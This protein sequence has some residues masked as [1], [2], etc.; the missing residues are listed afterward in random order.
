MSVEDMRKRP[1]VGEN[2]NAQKVAV[3]WN[4]QTSF[5][6]MGEGLCQSSPSARKLYDYT[7]RTLGVSL[8]SLHLKDLE[9][10]DTQGVQ[11]A[12]AP[13]NMASWNELRALYPGL[14]IQ[15]LGGH[16][17]GE[18]FASVPAGAVT[19]DNFLAFL[20]TR[21]ELMKSVNEQNPGA[22][23]ALTTRR[24][25]T[26][27][28]RDEKLQAFPEISRELQEKFGV[29]VATYSSSSRQTIGGRLEAVQEA[30][31]YAKRLR[32]YVVAQIISLN[33]APHTSLYAPIVDDLRSAIRSIR[34]GIVDPVIP[35]LT[36]SKPNPEIMTT[37]QAIE[38]EIVAQATQPVYGDKQQAFLL[39][40]GFAVIQIGEK[41]MIAEN[42]VEDFGDEVEMERVESHTGRTIALGVGGALV[43]G[44]A[45]TLGWKVTH[46]KKLN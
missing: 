3:L 8:N 21:T 17:F 25:K 1:E 20:K 44:A 23:M 33:G 18:G 7:A 36:C 2:L 4:G 32:N 13:Y 31:E 42:I 6:G 46:R 26:M 30:I 39:Q 45:L 37:A 11:F 16:S 22:L 24:S 9:N 40:N 29:E 15:I 28:E 12:N 43:T 19:Y 14:Q 41:P 34:D 5:T 10:P 35:M 38:D 27:E